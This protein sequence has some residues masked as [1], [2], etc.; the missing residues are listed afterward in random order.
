[1]WSGIVRKIFLLLSSNSEDKMKSCVY[2]YSNGVLLLVIGID[3]EAL[4]TWVGRLFEKPEE[5]M[6]YSHCKLDIQGSPICHQL[7]LHFFYIRAPL[8]EYGDSRFLYISPIMLSQEHTGHNWVNNC[9]SSYFVLHNW[10]SYI[11][12]TPDIEFFNH[13]CQWM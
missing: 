11:R 3:L 13:N 1:M 2:F 8:L 9:V 6:F 4:C 12:F 7:F 5:N 10:F